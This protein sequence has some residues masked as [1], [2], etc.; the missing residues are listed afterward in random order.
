MTGRSRSEHF[1]ECISLYLSLS[2]GKDTLARRPASFCEYFDKLL[3]GEVGRH[4]KGQLEGQR[5]VSVQ[6][7]TWL[8]S[9][10][11]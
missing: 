5:A 1:S 6:L 2:L 8:T 4:P 7:T 9:R 3:D 11:G 10:G